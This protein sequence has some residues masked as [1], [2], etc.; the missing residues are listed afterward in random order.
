MWLSSVEKFYILKCKLSFQ[1]QIDF[2]AIYGCLVR[3]Y[4]KQSK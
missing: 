3:D 4:V 1:F 2:V